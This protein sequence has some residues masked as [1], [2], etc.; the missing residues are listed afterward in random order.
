MNNFIIKPNAFLVKFKRRKTTFVNFSINS[1]CKAS[2][3]IAFS[4]Y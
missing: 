3:L 2:K 4:S 1:N